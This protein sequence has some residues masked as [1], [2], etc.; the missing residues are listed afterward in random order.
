M[1]H[2]IVFFLLFF[3]AI[4]VPNIAF[5]RAWLG[6]L[7]GYIA[8]TTFALVF[9]YIDGRGTKFQAIAMLFCG[10]YANLASAIL[11]SI[12]YVAHLFVMSRKARR[13]T[14]NC[15]TCGYCLYGNQS[16]ICPECGTKIPTTQQGVRPSE[17]RTRVRG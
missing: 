11:S 9:M 10:V 5:K 13:N 1:M 8:G 16:G 17:P 12:I 14:S 2:P 4:L 3:L 7:V 6:S 15:R